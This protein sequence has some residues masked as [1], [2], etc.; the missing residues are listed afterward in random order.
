MQ[1]RGVGRGI[2][3][4]SVGVGVL[5]ALTA[6]AP[7]AGNATGASAVT[8]RAATLAVVGPSPGRFTGEGFDACTAPSQATM[9]AW[10]AASPYRAIG[11]YFG[12]INRGCTQA[13]LTPAWVATQQ[14]KGWHLMPLY[15]GLQAPCTTSSKRNLIDPANA[16]AQGRAQAED[17]VAQATALG[18]ARESMLIY[19]MEAYTTGDATCRSAVLTFMSAWTAR[20]HDLGYLSGF[21]SSMGSGVVDQVAAYKSYGYVR[22]DYV[23]FA[24]W[25]NISTVSDIGIPASYWSPQRRIKQYRGDHLETWGG[26]TINIDNDYL[27]VAPL[28][29]TPFGDFTGNGWSDVVG[30]YSTGNLYLYPGNGISLGARTTIGTSWNGM[31]AIIRMGDFN[32][33]GR[34]DLI[35]RQAA[36]GYLFLYRGTGSALS[37]PLRIGTSWNSMRELTPI[38]DLNRDGYPDLLAVQSATGALYLYPGRGTSLGPRLSLGTGWNSLDELAG[39]GD[40][41]R[42]GAPDLIARQKATGELF[43]YPGRTSRFGPRVRI[44]T[45]GW[46]NLRDLVGVGDFNRDGYPDLITV[47]KSTGLL[48]LYPGR[49]TGLG[50]RS[51]TASGW[52]AIQPVL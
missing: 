30:R 34:E 41:N 20:L 5:V 45:S 42:D 11:I 48:Y 25:D 52:G 3:A 9:D 33:D 39:V 8:A 10:L 17:A 7:N 19:D 28:P 35:A 32:R 38:G 14:A 4:L 12:G 1:F 40:F 49:G 6:T 46:N 37:K 26:V 43:L 29:A 50:P 24:R 22:P 21:Y 13:N 51:K 36:T 27:D 23:D 16:A 18:L 44:G 31:N 2:R 47:E 15:V